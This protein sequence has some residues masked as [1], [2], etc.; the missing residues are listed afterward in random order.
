RRHILESKTA[1]TTGI[2]L[3]RRVALEL[4]GD[5]VGN[6]DLDGAPASDVTRI[7]VRRRRA[8]RGR[9]ARAR[10]QSERGDDETELARHAWLQRDWRLLQNSEDVPRSHRDLR[11]LGPDRVGHGIG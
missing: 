5:L 2:D 6:D 3:V 4:W 1:R 11:D 7:P 8:A 10:D 9:G